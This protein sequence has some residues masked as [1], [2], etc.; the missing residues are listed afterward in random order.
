MPL[1]PQA[2]DTLSGL[3]RVEKIFG[4]SDWALRTLHGQRVG[5][6]FQ[7]DLAL[8]L[9]ELVSAGLVSLRQGRYRLLTMPTPS[10][11]GR[12][13]RLSPLASL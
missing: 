5:P 2:L 3:E 7:T 9:E 4:V 13:K 8:A 6:A 12:R 11:P 10:K 1:S